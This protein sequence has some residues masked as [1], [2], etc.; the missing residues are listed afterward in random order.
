MACNSTNK[1]AVFPKRVKGSSV[2]NVKI[3]YD[4][5]VKSV[6][7]DLKL[8]HLSYCLSRGNEAPQCRKSMINISKRR[9]DTKKSP[10]NATR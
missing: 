6:Q 2:L 10:R 4:F 5:N 1:S 9:Q 7:S 3:F 8:T